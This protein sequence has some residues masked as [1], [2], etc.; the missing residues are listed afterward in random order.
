MGRNSDVGVQEASQAL[1]QDR[2]NRKLTK[3]P[4]VTYGPTDGHTDERTEK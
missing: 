1:R 3:P 2:R 4:N